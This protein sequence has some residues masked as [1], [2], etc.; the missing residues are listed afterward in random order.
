MRGI[1]PVT[2]EARCLGFDTPRPDEGYPCRLFL[3]LNLDEIEDYE[4]R[5]ALN[6]WVKYAAGWRCGP[7][8]RWRGDAK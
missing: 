4:E 2:W 3:S 5:L 1:T 6:G 7:C 8:A